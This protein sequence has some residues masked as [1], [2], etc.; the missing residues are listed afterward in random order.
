MW[1]YLSRPR[2]FGYLFFCRSKITKK[3]RNIACLATDIV[4]KDPQVRNLK[5][6]QSFFCVYC[7]S[8][9]LLMF[10]DLC[11]HVQ[12]QIVWWAKRKIHTLNAK[13]YLVRRLVHTWYLAL[14]VVGW[15]RRHPLGLSNEIVLQTECLSNCLNLFFQSYLLHKLQ[16]VLV[17]FLYQIL[18]S[19]YLYLLL[20]HHVFWLW[21]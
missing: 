15:G 7:I 5:K 19:S 8:D 9:S 18:C 4:D 17:S 6:Y 20:S 11:S 14:N 10:I 13:K 12:W 21:F 2:S 1:L 3:H 16:L